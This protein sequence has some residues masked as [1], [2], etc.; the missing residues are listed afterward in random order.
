MYD[1]L[2]RENRLLEMTS[3]DDPFLL[4]QTECEQDQLPAQISTDDEE[5]IVPIEKM[6]D[7]DIIDDELEFKCPIQSRCAIDNAQQTDLNSHESVEQYQNRNSRLVSYTCL[8]VLL[9]LPFIFGRF[10]TPWGKMIAS[11]F[12]ASS[13]VFIRSTNDESD[14][15]RAGKDQSTSE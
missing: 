2:E 11:I 14:C 10:I 12:I 7:S 15:E 13:L 1:D 5:L 6:N 4:A 3:I 9:M 8:I